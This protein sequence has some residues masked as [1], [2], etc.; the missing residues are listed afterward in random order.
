[1]SNAYAVAT[2]TAGLRALLTPAAAI[3]PG[4]VVTNLRPDALTVGQQSRGINIYLY[5]VRPNPHHMT[6]QLATRRHDGRLLQPVVEVLDLHYLLSFYGNDALL[7]PQLL[8]G[9]AS[10]ALRQ[11]PILTPSVVKDAKDANLDVLGASD[12]AEQRPCVQITHQSLSLE[13]MSKLWTTL[14]QT[15]YLLSTNCICQGVFV[16]GK[17]PPSVPTQGVPRP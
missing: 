9:A 8:L 5:M 7:E 12:L 2:V 16:E 14:I 3:V 6:E 13:E 17:P 4:S 1:M 11:Q 15:R 10:V